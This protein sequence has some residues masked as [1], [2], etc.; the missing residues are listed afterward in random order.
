MGKEAEIDEWQRLQVE[1]AG[2][3]GGGGGHGHGMAVGVPFER[4][5]LFLFLFLFFPQLASLS[6]SQKMVREERGWVVGVSRDCFK[7]PFHFPHTTS[8]L[9]GLVNLSRPT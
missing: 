2:G 4:S 7:G 1:T 3:C 5:F 6:Q 8:I 9:V